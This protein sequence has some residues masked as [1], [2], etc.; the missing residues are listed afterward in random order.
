[1]RDDAEVAG[2][3]ATVL[4]LDER[5]HPFVADLSPC[6]AEN[7][8]VISHVRSRLIAQPRNNFD[9]RW[10]SQPGTTGK[11]RGAAGDVDLRRPRRCAPCGLA[12][13]A[14]RL[15]RDAAGVHDRDV[16]PSRGLA[17]AVRDESRTDLLGV[18]VR[19][20]APEK[21][22]GERRHRGAC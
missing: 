7:T 12:G 19:D 3:A 8:D 6:A 20:L 21:P 17:M 1:V 14:H 11:V 5:A 10:K 2:E 15:V 22:D 16:R 4:H 18:S 13:F 9:V